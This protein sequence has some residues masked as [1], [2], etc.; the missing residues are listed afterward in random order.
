MRI[1]TLIAL[2]AL[3]PGLAAAPASAAGVHRWIIE[4]RYGDV[5]KDPTQP[6]NWQANPVVGHIWVHTPVIDLGEIDEND[7]DQ[8]NLNLSKVFCEAA[9]AKV[10][11]AVALSA[12]SCDRGYMAS[13]FRSREEAEAALAQDHGYFDASTSPGKQEIVLDA[14]Q[15]PDFTSVNMA[16]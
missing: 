12:L 8:A 10:G 2:T 11:E 6:Y 4:S 16:G 14:L 1:V 13:V 7:E 5:L 3:A 9:K 15:I